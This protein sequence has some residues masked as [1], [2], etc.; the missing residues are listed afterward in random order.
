[1]KLVVLAEVYE[2]HDLRA[3]G[4]ERSIHGVSKQTQKLAHIYTHTER[5]RENASPYIFFEAGAAEANGCL[6]E[7]WSLELSNTLSLLSLSLSLSGV[8]LNHTDSDAARD[9]SMK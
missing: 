9:A 6:Q 3:V 4:A 5:D 7:V 2:S 8:T 1:M